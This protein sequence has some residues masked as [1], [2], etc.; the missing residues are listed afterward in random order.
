MNGDTAT[1]S[2]DK[3]PKSVPEL[4]SSLRHLAETQPKAVRGTVHI[5]PA[6]VYANESSNVAESSATGASKA[7]DR[8]IT[9]W[10]M[11]EHMYLQRNNPFPTLARGL[12][13]EELEGPVGPTEAAGGSEVA[14][15]SVANHKRDRI[16]ARGYD[17]F[18]NIDEVAWTNVC[19]S[20]PSIRAVLMSSGPRWSS[21]RKRHTT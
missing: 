5:Y 18:F 2:T 13:T 19:T 12:F 8:R 11:T 4:L 16:V 7:R 17:K 9:S 21:I 20:C 15:E 6:E 3:H 10:K 1:M 14:G